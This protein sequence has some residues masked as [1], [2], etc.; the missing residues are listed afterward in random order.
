MLPINSCARLIK[1]GD[2]IVL[3]PAPTDQIKSP[4]RAFYMTNDRSSRL[5]G[6]CACM[7][8]IKPEADSDRAKHSPND[9]FHRHR[10]IP[11]LCKFPL[12]C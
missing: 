5:R 7:P 6:L 2:E 9:M 11:I 8:D 3:N 12:V 4:R 10:A 1:S